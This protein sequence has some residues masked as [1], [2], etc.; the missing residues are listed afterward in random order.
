MI[1]ARTSRVPTSM[2]AAAPPAPPPLLITTNANVAVPAKNAS[3][4]G[5]SAA[6]SGPENMVS[7]SRVAAAGSAPSST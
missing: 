3:I 2:I 6:M 5:A 4:A 7:N 1:S